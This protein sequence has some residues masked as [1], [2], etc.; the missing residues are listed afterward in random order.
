MIRFGS[1]SPAGETPRRGRIVFDCLLFLVAI[2]TC[3]VAFVYAVS[4]SCTTV[5]EVPAITRA[6]AIC[7]ALNR[8]RPDPGCT[9]RVKRRI[10]IEIVPVG[11]VP[12]AAYFELYVGGQMIGTY[13]IEGA[14][15]VDLDTLDAGMIHRQLYLRIGDAEIQETI[16]DK[17]RAGRGVFYIESIVEWIEPPIEGQ[18]AYLAGVGALAR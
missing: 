2:V 11:H 13:P 17:V 7:Q 4:G 8:D 5:P 18:P 16:K 3:L 9:W 10:G 1:A 15:P 6:N 12:E 14:I